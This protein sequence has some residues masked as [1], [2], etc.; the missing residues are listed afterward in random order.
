MTTW[1]HST[2]AADFRGMTG[3]VELAADLIGDA[4]CQ[5]SRPSRL[6]LRWNRART[7]FVLAAVL[8]VFVPAHSQGQ[9]IL[10][11]GLSQTGS[12]TSTSKT[13][14]WE[15]SAQ[16]GDA[17]VVRIGDKANSA[18]SP[19]IQLTGPSLTIVTSSFGA[20]VAELSATAIDSGTYRIFVTDRNGNQSGDYRI[21]LA[22]TRD[23]VAV[24][25]GDEGG[26][27]TNGASHAGVIETGDLDL[28]TF[29]AAAG[30]SIV[31]R[32][33]EVNAG[34][35]LVPF[36][37]LYGPNGALLSSSYLATSAEVSTRATNSGTFL[38]VVG[39]AAGG[40][41]GT[42]AYRL[43]LAKTSD[44]VV[45]SPGDEGGLLTNGV[46]HAGVIE[47]GDLDLWTFTAAAGDSIVIHMGEVNAGSTLVPF[48]RLYGPNGALLDSSYLAT[49]A[50]VSTRA[51]NS[52][53]F[54][55][56]VGDAAGGYTGT[57]AYRLTLAK[58]SDPVVVSP[59]DEGGPLTNGVSHAGVI[60]PGDLDLWTFT[61]AAGDSIVIRMGEVNAGS[62]LVP[63]LRLYG[64]NGALLDSS[65]L[66]TAA[67]VSTRATNSGTFL[68]VVGDAA[69]GYTGTGAYRLTLAKTGD[70][71]VISSGDEGGPLTNGVSHAGVIEAGD[72]DLW[73]FTAA[74][75]DSIV[76]R[77]GE[78]NPGSTLVPFLRLYGPNGA[79][80]DSG[81]LATAAE[82]STRATNSGTF[83]LVVGDAAGGYT[84]TGAYRLTLAKTGDPVV[85]SSG[86]EGGPLTNGV[87]HTGEIE[88]GGLA[89][90]TF[91]ACDGDTI[92]LQLSDVNSST[93]FLP[94]MRLYAPD[95][96]IL[97]SKSGATSVL[98]DR[99]VPQLGTYSLV[100]CDAS[101]GLGGS[102]A[103]QLTGLGITTGLS[104]CV[105]LV[106]ETDL[107]LRAA[108][109]RP[110][111]SYVLLTTTNAITL[112]ASWTPIWTNQFGKLGEFR[113]TNQFN[114]LGPA[115][116]YRVHS[117]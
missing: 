5:F 2:N 103:Y 62:T 108:G 25:P 28:W 68:L 59:G 87:S 1:P 101:G 89:I 66:A 49:A 17:I 72:L 13:N 21:T 116:Y 82:V 80:L 85:V 96:T 29:T 51:T 40:Y 7:C 58:T 100:V 35:T 92:H 31:I 20:S 105:P 38:L 94:W 91:N 8:W 53:T 11:N 63:F 81:Y 23:P 113:N 55:L 48:L 115:R 44:P 39:D 18:F 27:L 76:I 112:P 46:S 83:L 15:F 54:L 69:G 110:S 3:C 88:T 19:Q 43:T 4:L 50:E 9:N 104:L 86:D 111:D 74:A 67:E 107:V 14:I 78:V 16:A 60:E 41:T 22:K 36:L 117:P 26:P 109:G 93:S 30:D 75:G 24:S 71:V 70:P 42:G 98:V 61:A 65:Y 52:G 73:T 56:V 79:L 95:G 32:M 34:S 90:W 33:G 77:M 102:G 47:T 84:G 114:R 106:N 99:K 64:P 57:G 45:V 37:R 12:I 97:D 6:K 10:T